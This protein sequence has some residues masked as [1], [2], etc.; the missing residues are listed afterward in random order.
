VHNTR[1]IACVV[2]SSRLN[3]DEFEIGAERRRRHR[4][5]PN[6][7][8]G[9]RCNPAGSPATVGAQALA[10]DG[11]TVRSARRPWTSDSR[12]LRCPPGV[13]M[14]PM[15]PAEAHRVT[16]FGST[17]NIKATSPG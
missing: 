5:E 4:D 13:R 12:N 10:G 17:L 16:V 2:R 6:H 11:R 3:V 15:R 8:H 7:D 9:T 14:D 1:R